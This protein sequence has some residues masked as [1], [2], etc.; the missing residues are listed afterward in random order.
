MA[1]RKSCD[2]PKEKGERDGDTSIRG[3]ERT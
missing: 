1:K 3:E 2:E